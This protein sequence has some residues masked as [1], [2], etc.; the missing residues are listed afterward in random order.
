MIS[1]RKRRSELSPK[2]NMNQN[3]ATSWL[4]KTRTMFLS[5]CL[6]WKIAPVPR[7]DILKNKIYIQQYYQP[8]CGQ[9]LCLELCSCDSVDGA[10]RTPWSWQM[11]CLNYSNR[12][13]RQS[14]FP[15]FI[16]CQRQD[17][18]VL[19]KRRQSHE[20]DKLSD[21]STVPLVARWP[22]CLARGSDADG[23]PHSTTAFGVYVGGWE[24]AFALLR[25]TLASAALQQALLCRFFIPHT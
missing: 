5:S 1:R 2:S 12:T 13:R 15:T 6:C 21:V 9:L 18:N 11:Y 3:K 23:E 14:G 17:P 19:P 16:S 20:G 4:N 8:L 25:E 22:V 10:L 7:V 24:A